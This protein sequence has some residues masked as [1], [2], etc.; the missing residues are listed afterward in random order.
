MENA[1]KALLIAAAVL[2]VIL[3]VAFSMKIFN[4]TG[5]TSLDAQLTA[6]AI[7]SATTSAKIRAILNLI[8]IYDEKAFSTFVKS[9]YEGTQSTDRIIELMQIIMYRTQKVTNSNKIYEGSITRITAD[10]SNS[11]VYYDSVT[12]PSAYI[13]NL[14]KGKT[15][16]VR[17]HSYGGQTANT[18]SVKVTKE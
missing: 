14:E 11:L 16:V 9:E 13:C 5:D 7:A 2:I 15:Y 6:D 12:S 10:G 17:F 18:Y 8:D 3:L 1:S 4:S